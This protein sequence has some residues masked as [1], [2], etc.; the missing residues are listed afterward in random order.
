MLST[1]ITLNLLGLVNAGYLVWKQYGPRRGPLVCP[2]GQ[3][4]ELVLESKYGRLF[5]GI[6]NTVIGVG[7]YILTILLLVLA[8]QEKA[9]P[10]SFFGTSSP[11]LF[12]FYLSIPAFITS[13]ILTGIQHFVLKNYCSY[14]LFANFFNAVIFIGLF[15]AAV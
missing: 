15:I 5:W 7:Y 14:C 4:C 3:S 10:F 12:A 1:L 6:P 2:F 13:V 9:L 11:L 8:W